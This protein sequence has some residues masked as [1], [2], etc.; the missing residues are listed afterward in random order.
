MAVWKISGNELPVFY[1][2][3]DSFD[4]A[5]SIARQKKHKNDV[6]QRLV[7]IKKEL[8]KKL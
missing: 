6:L 1:V 4:K 8:I 3:A 7:D 5:L 2:K